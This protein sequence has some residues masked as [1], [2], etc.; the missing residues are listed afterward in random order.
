MKT[1]ALLRLNI[2]GGFR[3]AA[4]LHAFKSF[5]FDVYVEGFFIFFNKI[6]EQLT[7]MSTAQKLH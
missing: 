3:C 2:L 5:A 7:Q 4:D 6:P 1:G